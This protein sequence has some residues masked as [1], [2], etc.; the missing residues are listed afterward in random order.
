M[1]IDVRVVQVNPDVEVQYQ[2]LPS[3]DP[4]KRRP[5]IT[6]ARTHLKWEPRVPLEE[7]LERTIVDFRER[8]EKAQ[9]EAERVASRKSSRVY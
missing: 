9:L 1:F 2:P 7:G 6:L 4:K 8:M 3:D 5:D